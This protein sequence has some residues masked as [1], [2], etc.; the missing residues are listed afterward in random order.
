MALS[1]VLKH[2]SFEDEEFDGHLAFTNSRKNPC[3]ATHGD[4]FF[5]LF[6]VSLFYFAI[7]YFQQL[8]GEHYGFDHYL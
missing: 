1:K 4:F 2:F 8:H 3:I 5:L 6:F 7:L